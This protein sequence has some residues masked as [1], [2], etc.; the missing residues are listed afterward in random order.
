[1]DVSKSA[2]PLSP[3]VRI[4]INPYIPD[5]NRLQEAL[6]DA[7]LNYYAIDAECRKYFGSEQRERG[8]GRALEQ[9][10]EAKL[11]ALMKACADLRK[12]TGPKTK[13]LPHKSRRTA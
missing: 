11:E 1:M 2:P 3:A 5:R 10:S 9:E 13:T 7:A 4:C 8:R 12:Y 6:L